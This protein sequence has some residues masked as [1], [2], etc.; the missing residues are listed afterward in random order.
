MGKFLV[1]LSCLKKKTECETNLH[2]T[3]K[4]WLNREGKSSDGTPMSTHVLHMFVL[5]NLLQLLDLY[6]LP[7]DRE[8]WKEAKTKNELSER[9]CI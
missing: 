8:V 7:K 1:H 6:S 5:D 4:Y 3:C 2:N 9:I